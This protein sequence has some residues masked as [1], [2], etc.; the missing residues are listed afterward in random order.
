MTSHGAVRLAA[1]L[2]ERA[3]FKRDLASLLIV[4]DVEY[5]PHTWSWEIEDVCEAP[6]GELPPGLS[7]RAV[8]WL[9]AVGDKV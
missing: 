5:R 7:P 6:I 2:D 1:E 4:E 8:R 9:E 3:D